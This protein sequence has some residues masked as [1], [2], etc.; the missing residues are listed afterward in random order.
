MIKD[1]NYFY[2]NKSMNKTRYKSET[3]TRKR[4]RR[5]LSDQYGNKR[6]TIL[7][8]RRRDSF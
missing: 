3:K 5:N 6:R 8:N 7:D 1:F 4:H 2:W